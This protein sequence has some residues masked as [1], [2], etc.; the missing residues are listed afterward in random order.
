MYSTFVCQYPL[1]IAEGRI[2]CSQIKRWH[3]ILILA[4]NKHDVGWLCKYSLF[5]QDHAGLDASLPGNTL[6][7][8]VRKNL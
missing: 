3:K 6:D 1:S 8:S 5:A 2:R 7:V 4:G